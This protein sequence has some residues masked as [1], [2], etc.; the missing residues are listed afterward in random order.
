ML[1]VA[2]ALVSL[3]GAAI[4]G[5][6]PPPPAGSH[7]VFAS[8]DLPSL[9]LIPPDAANPHGTLLAAANAPNWEHS[10]QMRRSQDGGLTWSNASAPEYTVAGNPVCPKPHRPGLCA[11]SSPQQVWDPT[12]QRAVLQFGLQAV[13]RNATACDGTTGLYGTHQTV[14]TDRGQT[15]GWKIILF[16][17]N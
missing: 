2:G 13:M 9:L 7:V 14:S 5:G 6:P 4:A 8:G 10:I 3:A 15:W 16:I 11:W 1:R 12:G 17:Q